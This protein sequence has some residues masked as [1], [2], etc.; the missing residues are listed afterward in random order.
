MA[1]TRDDIKYWLNNA[2]SK[3][4]TH[5]IVVCDTFD[6]EDYPVYVSADQSVRDVY[7]EYHM[8]NMQKVMEVYDLSLDLDMQINEYRSMHL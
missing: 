2:K 3:N 7:F 1:A 5:L 4:A 6:W 8:K